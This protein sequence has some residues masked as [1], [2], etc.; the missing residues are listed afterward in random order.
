MTAADAVLTKP[1]YGTFVEA[2]CN[3]TPV[4]YVPRGDWP[5]ETPLVTWLQQ[6]L[7][8]IAVDRKQAIRGDFSDL[9]DRLWQQPRPNPP[10][11]TGIAEAADLIV[12]Y[13]G[14]TKA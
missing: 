11:P 12:A 1:G 6:H 4:I 7:A 9:L 5:E 2:A 13:L 3:G 8:T 10:E 14:E